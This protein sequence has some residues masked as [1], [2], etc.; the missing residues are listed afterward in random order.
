MGTRRSATESGFLPHE[1]RTAPQVESVDGFEILVSSPPP[2]PAADDSQADPEKGLGEDSSGSMAYYVAGLVLLVVVAG[3]IF[4]PVRPDAVV[5]SNAVMDRVTMP[6]GEKHDLEHA[7][8]YATSGRSQEGNE[9][10]WRLYDL[11]T[12]VSTDIRQALQCDK[13]NKYRYLLT[14]GYD[15]SPADLGGYWLGH[16]LDEKEWITIIGPDKKHQKH[17]DVRGKT[18]TSLPTLEALK[19]VYALDEAKAVLAQYGLEQHFDITARRPKDLDEVNVKTK[20]KEAGHANIAVK[21]SDD[22]NSSQS[23][24]ERRIR[25]QHSPRPNRRRLTESRFEELCRRLDPNRQ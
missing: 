20:M 11:E 3:I 7:A 9:G 19:K 16:R 6:G 15:D 4:L 14:Y 23:P 21:L 18:L 5:K 25:S 1:Q 8:D 2:H 17:G 22:G 24:L 10:I 12:R 13:D